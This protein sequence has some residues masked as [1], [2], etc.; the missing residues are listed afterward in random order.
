[1]KISQNRSSKFKTMKMKHL[2][3]LYFSFMAI[4]LSAQE[5]SEIQF[6]TLTVKNGYRFENNHRLYLAYQFIYPL[7]S[8]ISI[9][10]VKEH[11][12]REF[13]G[14]EKENNTSN[15]LDA[16]KEFY[17]KRIINEVL[18]QLKVDEDDYTGK[19]YDEQ[20]SAIRIINNNVLVYM[21]II[22]IEA[23]YMD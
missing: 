19:N 13:F 8:T 14:Y 7:N 22:G 12:I 3:L 6:D 11:V 2:L 4:T 16:S 23:E 9:D 10:K 5:S 1:M 15:L 17:E 20:Y 18:D 21:I